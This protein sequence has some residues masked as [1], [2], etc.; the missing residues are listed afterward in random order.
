MQLLETKLLWALSQTNDVKNWAGILPTVELDI[1]S[2]PNKNSGYSPF[3]LNFGYHPTGPADLLCGKEETS[4]EKIGTFCKRMKEV[5]DIAY[6]NMQ[7]A[8]A[9]QA[10]YYNKRHKMIDF[11]IGNLVLLNTVYLRLKGVSGKLHKKY[12]GI[13][14]Y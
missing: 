12:W 10:K 7:K 3:F 8:V 13:Q 4:D 1:N 6:G 5:W 14:S 11:K 2:L 9:L